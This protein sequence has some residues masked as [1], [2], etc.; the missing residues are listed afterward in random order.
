MN[1]DRTL[2]YWVD[3]GGTVLRVAGS[4]DTWLED[5][6]ELSELARAVNVVGRDL[7][8][9]VEN[10][11]VALVYQAL[12]ARV[13]ETGKAIEFP[14]RCDSAWLRREMRMRM[15]LEGGL[16]RYDS[17]IIRETRRERPLPRAA[18]AADILVA[19]CSFCKGYRF[20]TES[21]LWKDIESLFGEPGLPEL[22]ALTHG[23]CEGCAAVCFHDF[24]V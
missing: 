22:F 7:F 10:E 20:P 23:M 12:Q 21:K 16:L 1:A 14:F 9:F 2:S 17:T 18:A 5:D 13:F 19:M 15:S 3:S 11:S 24:S 8:S 6:D 4:W